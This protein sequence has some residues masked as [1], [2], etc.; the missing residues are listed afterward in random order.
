[1]SVMHLDRKKIQSDFLDELDRKV[2]DVKSS[3]KVL[4]GADKSSNYYQ[5]SKEHHDLLMMKAIRSSWVTLD[6]RDFRLVFFFLEGF[7]DVSGSA[8]ELSATF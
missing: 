5:M 7:S 8:V 2:K 6:L 1:M 3:D 4:V